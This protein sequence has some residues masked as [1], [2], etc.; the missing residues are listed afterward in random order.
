MLWF[1]GHGCAC[2]GAHPSTPASSTANTGTY[3]CTYHG[4]IALRDRRNSRSISGKGITKTQCCKPCECGQ[5]HDISGALGAERVR[6]N[7]S[8]FTPP[9]VSPA[10]RSSP[11]LTTSPDTKIQFT[12]HAGRKSAARF[13]SRRRHSAATMR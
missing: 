7:V 12:T 11:G 3:T 1:S 8:A 13:A 6:T 5:R 4:C 9:P 10:T 2:A